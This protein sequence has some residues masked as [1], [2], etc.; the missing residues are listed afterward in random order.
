MT[1]LVLRPGT[2]TMEID[3]FSGFELAVPLS[4]GQLVM[5]LDLRDFR[6]SHKA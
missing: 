2:R 6:L 4:I 1:G 3:R 5:R